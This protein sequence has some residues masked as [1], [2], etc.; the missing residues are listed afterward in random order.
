[1]KAILLELVAAAQ[2]ANAKEAYRVVLRSLLDEAF[3]IIDRDAVLDRYHPFVAA[4]LK[5]WRAPAAINEKAVGEVERLAKVILGNLDGYWDNGVTLVLDLLQAADKRKKKELYAATMN[6]GVETISRG[7]APDHL[8]NTFIQNVLTKSSASFTDRVAAM[9]QDFAKGWKEFSCVILTEGIKRDQAGR[10]PPD[11]RLEFGRPA[12]VTGPAERFYKRVSGDTISLKVRVM[13]ADPEAARH[14]ADQRLAEVFAGLNLF[15]VDDR[16]V[17]KQTRVL[18]E[19]DNGKQTIVGYRRVGSQYLGNYDSRQVKLELLFRV[20]QSSAAKPDAAQLSAALQYHRL[21]MLATNDEARLVNLWIALEAL[22]QGG[23]GSIIERV[24]TRIA[25]C[26]SVDNVRKTIVSLALY[27]RFL[28]NDSDKADFLAL[29]PNSSEDRLDPED[30]LN[31]L[32]LPKDDPKIE[33]LCQLCARHPLIVHRLFRAKMMMLNSPTSVAEN[34]EYTRQNVDWQLKRIY[35]ARNAIVHTGRGSS[36]LP[37]LTQ[38]LHCYLMKTIH[39]VLL[40][41]DRQPDWSIRDALEHRRR[42][43]EHVVAFFR[44]TEGHE[45]SSR[46][47]MYPHECMNPQAAPFAWPP[48]PAPVPVAPTTTT[49]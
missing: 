36:L 45:I 44:K 38:H 47:V 42:L 2:I 28:W 33:R 46:A 39:S 43:F 3:A 25:P 21:A 4:Y 35:R 15:S 27:V 1:V 18:V 30:L 17:R 37:Q 41:L 49:S 9:F 31:L 19:D 11:T 16:F 32:L 23:D 14:F 12:E 13:A 22:C 7:H 6:L 20:E 8:R 29:F 24:S 26:V 34:L 10:L 5:P 40:E 48:P